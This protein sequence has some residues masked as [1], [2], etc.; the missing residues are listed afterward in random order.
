M[1]TNISQLRIRKDAVSSLRGKLFWPTTKLPDEGLDYVVGVIDGEEKVV[2]VPKSLLENVPEIKTAHYYLITYSGE[3]SPRKE[4]IKYNPLH[5]SV[6]F[7]ALKIKV[8][9]RPAHDSIW[10]GIED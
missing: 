7:G 1:S 3:D 10:A 5:V 2:S 6:P 4:L 9:Y 8:S